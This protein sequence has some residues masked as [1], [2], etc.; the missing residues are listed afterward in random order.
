ML[1]PN[2]WSLTLPGK[3][4]N[5]AILSVQPDK[6]EF[7][8]FRFDSLDLPPLPADLSDFDVHSALKDE[9]VLYMEPYSHYIHNT[10]YT[11]YQ[12]YFLSWWEH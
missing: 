4:D 3:L 12:N 7:D 2:V 6:Y 5:Y 10:Y 1:I 9:K 11:D 8:D